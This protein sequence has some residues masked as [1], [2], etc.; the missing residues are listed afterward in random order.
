MLIVNVFTRTMT[1][2]TKVL[3]FFHALR[4]SRLH[5]LATNF[6]IV[7]QFQMNEESS[8]APLLAINIIIF[9]I[10]ACGCGNLDTKLLYF[11]FS[12]SKTNTHFQIKSYDV[13]WWHSRETAIAENKN[14][15]RRYFVE[16]IAFVIY[17]LL[18]FVPA[19]TLRILQL[20]LILFSRIFLHFIDKQ[21]KNSLKCCLFIIYN[22]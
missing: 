7:H 16:V 17:L 10:Y 11:S 22:K 3:Y 6:K 2:G 18:L 14:I 21:W 9:R 5:S 19:R 1:A 12:I 15:Y 13:Q 4:E 20:L 8:S